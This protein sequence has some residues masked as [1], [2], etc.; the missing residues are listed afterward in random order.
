MGE[1]FP[2]NISNL[3]NT[4]IFVIVNSVELT[5]V[6]T[7][8]IIKEEYGLQYVFVIPAIAISLSGIWAAFLMPE[9]HG[10][11]LKQIRSIYSR[12]SESNHQSTKNAPIV[13]EIPPEEMG[14]NFLKNT[15]RKAT[16]TLWSVDVCVTSMKIVDGK[17]RFKPI[18]ELL[19]AVKAVINRKNPTLTTIIE[20]DGN[21][22]AVSIDEDKL[23]NNG[24]KNN[25]AYQKES[26]PPPEDL[27]RSV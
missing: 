12:K 16:M 4:A 8:L 3:A 22:S 15:V 9:T 18:Q 20:R 23:S 6:Y 10:L 27:K 14:R 5:T 17:H 25:F 26:L 24:S 21:Q 1:L 7:A 11:S 13:N 19:L 2:P